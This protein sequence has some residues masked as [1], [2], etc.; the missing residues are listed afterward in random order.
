MG[1]SEC[2]HIQPNEKLMHLHTTINHQIQF[3]IEDIQEHGSCS[4][5]GKKHYTIDATTI[6]RL[7]CVVKGIPFKEST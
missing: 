3:I 4:I 1:C 7:I 6:D 2:S 5:N